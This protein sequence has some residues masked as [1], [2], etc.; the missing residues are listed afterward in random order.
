MEGQ[1]S[2]RQKTIWIFVTQP[3]V[4]F[5]GEKAV[6]G[7]KGEQIQTAKQSRSEQTGDLRLTLQR[8]EDGEWEREPSFSSSA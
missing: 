7:P 5:I 8:L 1:I 4:V 3:F 6:L 2:G